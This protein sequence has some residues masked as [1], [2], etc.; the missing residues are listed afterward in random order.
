MTTKEFKN[1]TVIRK[2]IVRKS[3]AGSKHATDKSVVV[4]VKE[5]FQAT[6]HVKVEF[7]ACARSGDS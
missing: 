5:N 7:G 3:A 4:S 2:R 6:D 1:K